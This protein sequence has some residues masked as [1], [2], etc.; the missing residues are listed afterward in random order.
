[1]FNTTL[2]YKNIINNSQIIKITLKKI[3]SLNNYQNIM[4]NKKNMKLREIRENKMLQILHDG[5][6]IDNYLDI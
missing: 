2:S 4:S 1:M 3:M 5:V 6:G